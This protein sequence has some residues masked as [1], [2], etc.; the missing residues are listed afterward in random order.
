MNHVTLFLVGPAVAVS[1]WGGLLGLGSLL[2]PRDERQGRSQPGQNV[3]AA[4]RLKAR[5]LAAQRAAQLHRLLEQR[6]VQRVR[7]FP[8]GLRHFKDE[9]DRLPR[10]QLP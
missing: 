1:L 8:D 7:I 6:T 9:T 3:I 5:Q 4:Q 10:Q 2:C